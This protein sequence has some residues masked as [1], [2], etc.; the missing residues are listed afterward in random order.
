MEYYI[1]IADGKWPFYEGD[2]RL[3]VGVYEGEF[4]CPPEYAPVFTTPR[5]EVGE[6]T[7]VIYG[8]PVK[9][10]DQYFVT[11]VT[12]DLTPEQIAKLE[13]IKANPEL[14]FMPPQPENTGSISPANEEPVVFEHGAEVPL[15]HT[16]VQF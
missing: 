13:E 5:P 1:R 3:V 10:G 7:A 2:I 4:I 16:V 14:Y 12:Q 8:N 15:E 11:W 9:R 6:Y